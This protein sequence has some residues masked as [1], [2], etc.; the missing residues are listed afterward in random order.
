MPYKDK[1]KQRAYMQKYMIE[2]RRQRAKILKQARNQLGS[3]KQAMLVCQKYER[4]TARE[5]K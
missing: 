2:W 1:K 3:T 5:K 4:K